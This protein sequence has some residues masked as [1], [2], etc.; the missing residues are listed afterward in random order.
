MKNLIVKKSVLLSLMICL[1]GFGLSGCGNSAQLQSEIDTLKT[2][3]AAAQEENEKLKKQVE[4]LTKTVK[5][6][7]ELNAMLQEKAGSESE[8][9]K[10]EEKK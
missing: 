8:A 6:M 7:T 10:E 2:E 5:D 9:K 3:I 1:V 4:I